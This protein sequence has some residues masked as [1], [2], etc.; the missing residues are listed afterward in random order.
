[1]LTLR[2]VTISGLGYAEQNSVWLGIIGRRRVAMKSC[3]A[4]L[5][6]SN[7]RGKKFEF[8]LIRPLTNSTSGPYITQL[9]L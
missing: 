7:I 6:W 9:M 1:V 4:K 3:L 8:H 5:N 2:S